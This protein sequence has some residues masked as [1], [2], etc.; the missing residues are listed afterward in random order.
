M[1]DG[2]GAANGGPDFVVA[3][4]DGHHAIAD[5][6][7]HLAAV[8]LHELGLAAQRVVDAPEDLLRILASFLERGVR[9]EIGEQ[10]R[11][12]TPLARSGGAGVG[13]LDH[14]G[15][16]LGEELLHDLLFPQ[17]A[18]ERTEGRRES[19]NLAAG[20]SFHVA[21]IIPFADAIR[22]GHEL[23]KRARDAAREK[24]ARSDG[25]GDPEKTHEEHAPLKA[26]KRGELAIAGTE[27]GEETDRLLAS[28]G[29]G[30]E[31]RE[32]RLERLASKGQPHILR[33]RG[34]RS[35]GEPILQSR[36]AFLER[37]PRLLIAGLGPGEEHHFAVGE[38]LDV[39]RELVVDLVA[40]H[41]DAEHFIA[42]SERDGYR[43]VEAAFLPPDAAEAL[44]LDRLSHE[45]RP[46]QI[47][48]GESGNVGARDHPSLD[49]GHDHEV[50]SD[51]LDHGL[52]RVER[53]G[54]V[55]LGDR[56]F[57]IGALD[58]DRVD[59]LELLQAVGLQVLVELAGRGQRDA[60]R[61]LGELARAAVGEPEESAGEA[62]DEEE[63]DEENLRL[64]TEPGPEGVSTFHACTVF[65][66]CSCEAAWR[67]RSRR[68]EPRDPTPPT[69]S[70]KPAGPS[71]PPRA[72]LSTD[73]CRGERR[74]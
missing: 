42:H 8:A 31:R 30:R 59:E 61:V 28:T 5:E 9:L 41:D 43:V 70:P 12:G 37:R 58:D 45:G 66:T 72:T 35:R 27:R 57:E 63:R 6:L 39:L 51:L 20:G 73:S 64:K 7:V 44:S 23:P 15:R 55:H 18:Q 22:D 36:S 13:P 32:D 14:L 49:V 38:A 17:L 4:E 47:D 40:G 26:S 21:R 69:R 53:G 1:L 48:A 60:E 34:H 62:H 74:R 33:L 52:G 25:D 2:D 19:S 50:A 46:R 71:P 11:D 67:T 29:F 10:H 65:R 16:G 3:L 54:R 24:M 68:G 56:R